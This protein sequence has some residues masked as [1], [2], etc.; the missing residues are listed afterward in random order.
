MIY[1]TEITKANGTG[2]EQITFQFFPKELP[3][4]IPHMYSTKINRIEYNGGFITNQ[5]IGTFQQPIEWEGCFFGK[6]EIGGTVLTAKERAQQIKSFMGRPIRV[7]FSPPDDELQYK[8]GQTDA[9]L[10][11]DKGIYIIEEYEMRVRNYVDIDYKIRLVPHMR[12]EKIKPMDSDVVIVKVNEEAVLSSGLKA[13]SVAANSK[14][15]TLK[16]SAKA[17]VNSSRTMGPDAQIPPSVLREILN[18]PP[19]K[20]EK[21]LRLYKPTLAQQIYGNPQ[22]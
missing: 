9:K 21:L 20:A 18:S 1:F 19:K 7:G 17:A 13:N 4:F 16:N 5:I 8:V 15:K 12:Q 2:E 3:E 14:N 22:N 10:A 11:G 6:Y